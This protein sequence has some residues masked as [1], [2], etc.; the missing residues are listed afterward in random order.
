MTE[1]HYKIVEHDG[2]WAYTLDGVFSETHP[3]HDDALAAARRAAVEQERPGKTT[4]IEY[5]DR[6]GLWRTEL[7]EGGDRPIVDVED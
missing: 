7:S 6:S 1:I 3:T 5:Q 2:G 4:A